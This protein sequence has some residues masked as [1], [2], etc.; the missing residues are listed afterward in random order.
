MKDKGRGSS[1][2]PSSSDTASNAPQSISDTEHLSTST[3]Y[4][5]LPPKVNM[6]NSYSSVTLAASGLL[7][8][9]EP[10]ATRHVAVGLASSDSKQR[11]PAA[12]TMTDSLPENARSSGET[13]AIHKVTAARLNSDRHQ[14]TLH[15][16]MDRSR[17]SSPF[18]KSFLPSNTTPSKLQYIPPTGAAAHVQYIPPTGAPAHVQ[19]AADNNNGRPGPYMAHSGSYSGTLPSIPSDISD[20]DLAEAP[21]TLSLKVQSLTNRPGTSTPTRK[22]SPQSTLGRSYQATERSPSGAKMS[23]I[24]TENAALRAELDNLNVDRHVL[25]KVSERW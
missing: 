1:S 12:H 8:G 16:S 2:A 6:N 3:D 14:Q 13:D 7:S 18:D 11:V 22:I 19:S 24:E 21:D 25:H 20:I 10:P 23:T 9:H 5:Q 15:A 17:V 4:I